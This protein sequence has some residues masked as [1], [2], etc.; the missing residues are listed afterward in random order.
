L[1]IVDC[2]LKVG[3]GTTVGVRAFT[4][5][6]M[7]LVAGLVAVLAALVLP[8]LAGQIKSQELPASAD[9]LRSLI[10]LVQANA[11]F[12][13]RRFRIRFPREDETDPM[14]GTTQPIIEREDDPMHEPEVFYPVNDPWAF[15]ETFIGDV[16]CAQVRLGRPRIED[17]RDR[18]EQAAEDVTRTLSAKEQKE[19][20]EVDF[21]PLYI[22]PDGA[23]D[24]A[25]FLLTS[26]PAGIPPEELSVDFEAYP[27]IEVILEGH[28]GLCWLQRPFYDEELDLFEDKNWP[29]VLRQDF[30][31]K[32]P[33]TEND[34]LE[35][36]EIR[37]KQ[38][39]KAGPSSER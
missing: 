16:R 14:G 7:V 39:T 31:R 4:L 22:E 33:L 28:T 15:G 19:K 5:L 18:R 34:V 32:T 36:R 38:P 13:G 35:L 10:S 8:N 27:Q 24:W 23:A 3:G 2:R 17:L 21:P 30:L 37:I 9:Q 12:E 11:A 26:A 6:E 29:A 20:F 1:S 25:V